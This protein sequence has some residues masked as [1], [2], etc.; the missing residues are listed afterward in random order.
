[1]KN[2]NHK[3]RCAPENTGISLSNPDEVLF[4]KRAKQRLPVLAIMCSF[5]S[6]S[7]FAPIFVTYTPKHY[8][9]SNSWNTSNGIKVNGNVTKCHSTEME[10]ITLYEYESCPG[11][12]VYDRS[13]GNSMTI[14]F[15][16]VC[17]S[18][19]KK[20]VVASSI[21]LGYF[22]GSI[23]GSPISDR[24]GRK[25]ILVASIII[26]AISSLFCSF[27][28]SFLMVLSS[29]LFVGISTLIMYYTAF[30]LAQE[31]VPVN[32]KAIAATAMNLGYISGYLFLT[33]SF[34]LIR[35][36]RWLYRLTSIISAVYFIPF[37]WFVPES[38]KWL[39]NNKSK[40]N[41][42]TFKT[43]K[44]Q[45]LEDKDVNTGQLDS[46]VRRCCRFKLLQNSILVKR[47]A[48]ICLMW[49]V[50][51]LGF[52]ILN[53]NTSNLGGSIFVNSLVVGCVGMA[54]Y[55]CA[56]VWLKKVGR[57]KSFAC[58]LTLSSIFCIC[59]PSMKIVH[60]TAGMVFS[61]VG[62]HFMTT[63]ISIA[64]VWAGELFPTSLR[65]S[66]LGLASLSS[67]VFTIATPFVVYAGEELSYSIPFY[68]AG[69]LGAVTVVLSL[70][71]PETLETDLPNTTEEAM[72]LES[73]RMKIFQQLRFGKA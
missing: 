70:L 37:L 59:S 36:W 31:M 26:Y 42:T 14:E 23:I 56:M 3:I 46:R 15:N 29:L 51:N 20:P 40:Q 25:T 16:L 2:D 17:D 72:A 71:L 18:S 24:Y 9:K 27:S 62:I 44:L 33:L 66:Y 6:F 64:V 1:M 48:L 54:S 53:L 32:K 61:M 5:V 10:N 68:I 7:I 39:L 43:K 47:C 28:V 22:I 38:P 60:I 11:E 67:S 50:C 65:N 41:S 35:D 19:W 69:C 30:I 21:L 13:Q 73:K 58:S 52:Y 4:G 12:L 34:Y 49:I 45:D 63:S 8:C 57:R 55:L